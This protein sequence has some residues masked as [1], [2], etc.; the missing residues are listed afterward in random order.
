MKIRI[1]GIYQKTKT[2]ANGQVATYT[3]HRRTN[4]RLSANPESPEFLRQVLALDAG[5]E[6][7][8]PAER[9]G[10]HQIREYR[11]SAHFAN[12]AKRTREDYIR[13]MVC[14][15]PMIGPFSVA[16]I[17]RSHVTAIRNKLAKKH[18]RGRTPSCGSVPH[19]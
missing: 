12:M 7:P 10:A 1:K 4:T 11:D 3:Y 13:G 14:L 8:V 5:P 6:K 15:E 2:L 9:T 17:R 19:C 16:D 18:R